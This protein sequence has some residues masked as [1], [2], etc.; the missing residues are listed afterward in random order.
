MVDTAKNDIATLIER[1]YMK[2]RE[3]VKDFG[4]DE[5]VDNVVNTFHM[6]SATVIKTNDDYFCGLRANHFL[7]EYGWSE[8]DE[9]H[10]ILVTA[11]HKGFRMSVYFKVDDQTISQY[12]AALDTITPVSTVNTALE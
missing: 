1:Q 2:Q 6:T 12:F 7:V 5:K 10:L 11:N 8:E 3:L 9:G 4:Y